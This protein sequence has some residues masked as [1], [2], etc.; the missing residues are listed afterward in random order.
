MNRQ[1]K[2]RNTELIHSDRLEYPSSRQVGGYKR[3]LL[4]P[5]ALRSMRRVTVL[6]P[7]LIIDGASLPDLYGGFSP[8][9][10]VGD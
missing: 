9:S 3:E 5:F 4:Q 10:Q 7:G 1:K 2:F 8:L 6:M